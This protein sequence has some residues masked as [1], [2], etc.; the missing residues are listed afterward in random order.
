LHVMLQMNV[1]RNKASIDGAG[2]RGCVLETA[3][4]G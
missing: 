1:S 2:K 4:S 3:P